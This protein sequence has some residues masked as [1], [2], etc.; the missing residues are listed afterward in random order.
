MFKWGSVQNSMSA[1]VA[2]KGNILTIDSASTELT[3]T[4]Y[5]LRYHFKHLPPFMVWGRVI[6]G[7]QI[8]FNRWE[9]CF[10]K[11]DFSK[12]ITSEFIGSHESLLK[13]WED[14]GVVPVILVVPMKS[15]FMSSF[16]PSPLRQVGVWQTD[17][18]RSS[19]PIDH[20][21]KNLRTFLSL[22]PKRTIDLLGYYQ[23]F[24]IT[25]LSENLYLLSDSHW[26]SRGIAFAA[27][28]IIDHLIQ[29]KAIHP[30]FR[31]EVIAL[32][33]SIR[34]TPSISPPL[35]IP[36]SWVDTSHSLFSMEPLYGLRNRANKSY[37]GRVIIL[38][39][40]FSSRLRKRQLSLGDLVAKALDAPLVNI[41]INA[42][43]KNGALL[44]M[45]NRGFQLRPKDILVWEIPASEV[46]VPLEHPEASKTAS[47]SPS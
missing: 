29:R 18:D 12:N 6:E 5:L 22:A 45:L 42:G 24:P 47:Q 16:N 40:S 46:F 4:G 14:V 13:K 28:A 34:D 15:V 11:Y 20:L 1:L 9:S 26:S 36:L 27:K 41:T 17:P 30:S 19:P 39:T 37:A 21:E 31:P 25:S 23:T 35:R 7:K 43:G 44:S 2:R 33:E 3:H 10:Y 38:G 8:L 32:N